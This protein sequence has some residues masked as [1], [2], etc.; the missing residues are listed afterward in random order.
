M[1]APAVAFPLEPS[2]ASRLARVV[3]V[4]YL[5]ALL[6][7]RGQRH[8]LIVILAFVQPAAFVLITTLARR[9]RP[10]IEPS[11]IAL[12]AGLL[13]I[14]AA[15]VWQSGSILR[16]ER[17]Q[18]TLPGIVARPTSLA[19]VLI[20]KS[21]GGTAF[22]G[23][24]IGCTVFGV[25]AAFGDVVSVADPLPFLAALGGVVV[26]ASVLGI[27]ISYVYVVTRAATRIAEALMYPIFILGGMLVPLSLLPDSLTPLSAV[28]SLRWG[29]ELLRAAANG[30]P[31]AVHAWLLLAATTAAYALVARVLFSRVL[32]R[33]R[34][35]G[36][37]DL[38]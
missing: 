31:Q 25:S 37:L 12:G 2:R 7:I 8:P 21:L 10:D 34:N 11:E 33:A 28:V 5:S 16:A 35:E 20:G 9:G 3:H 27:L 1:S 13:S 30:E 26:S 17:W 29:A 23:F 38:Y 24:F 18:G 14:W 4:V 32:D 22:T 19:F 6:Q 36:T 15:T